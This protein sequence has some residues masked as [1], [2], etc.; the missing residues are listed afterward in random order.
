MVLIF[1]QFSKKPI[2]AGK[3]GGVVQVLHTK[4]GGSLLEIRKGERE[5][6][7][8]TEIY[9]THTIFWLLGSSLI[10]VIRI[11]NHSLCLKTTVCSPLQV[12]L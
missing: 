11:V 12:I 9:L 8:F 10:L 1:N 6:A 3:Q 2:K 5:R 7:Y 4:L